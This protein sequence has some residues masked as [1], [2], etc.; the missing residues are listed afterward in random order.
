MSNPVEIHP[1]ALN[2]PSSD[3]S[4]KQLFAFF[5]KDLRDRWQKRHQEL[6]WHDYLVKVYNIFDTSQSKI[7]SNKEFAKGVQGL[8]PFMTEK[9]CMDMY[10]LFG[11]KDVNDLIC[12]NRFMEHLEDL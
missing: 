4:S 6:T 11:V 8:L 2:A 9:N 3:A 1:S 12:V 7:L 10:L 5:K